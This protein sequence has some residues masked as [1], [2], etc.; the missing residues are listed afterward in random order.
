MPSGAAT[1][2]LQP[3]PERPTNEL[4]ALWQQLDAAAQAAAMV[5][6][7]ASLQTG[8]QQHV[9]GSVAQRAVL[10]LALQPW[11][12]PMLAP[13]A[14]CGQ[15]GTVTVQPELLADAPRLTSLLHRAMPPPPAKK[16]A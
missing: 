13:G 8:V 3:H 1:T 5:A 11:S 4:A 12:S 10:R 9:R 2:A 15:H 7:A 14:P 16:C 6:T